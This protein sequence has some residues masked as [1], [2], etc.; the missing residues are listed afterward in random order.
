M[1]GRKPTEQEIAEFERRLELNGGHFT[2]DQYVAIV[3]EF[4]QRL[5]PNREIKDLPEPFK[6]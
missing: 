3:S 5:P 4:V 2:R 1:T 6:I